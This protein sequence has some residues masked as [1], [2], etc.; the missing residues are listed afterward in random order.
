MS[1]KKYN[2]EIERILKKAKDLAKKAQHAS[3]TSLH[4]LW[5]LTTLRN[6]S[7]TKLLA[8]FD[9]NR[10]EVEEA[11]EHYIQSVNKPVQP[12]W[13]RKTKD[14]L[15][16][17]D[18]EVTE[19]HVEATSLHLLLALLMQDQS[20][21]GEVV[22][23]VTEGK[24]TDVIEAITEK[25]AAD[26]KEVPNLLRALS[27]ED[28]KQGQNPL[29]NLEQVGRNLTEM[30]KK[31]QLDPVFGRDKE[32]ERAL[33]ILGRRTKNNPVF[34]G[35]PGVGK[36]AIA[37][38]VAQRM[39]DGD[40]PQIFQDKE[41]WLLDISSVVAGTKYRGE[42]ENR[43]KN[44]IEEVRQAGNIILFIDELHTLIGAGGSE[45]SVDASNILKPALSRGEIQ[46]MGATTFDEY[47]KYIEKDRAFERRFAPIDIEEPS[48]EMTQKMLQGLSNYYA[49]YHNVVLSDEV[50]NVAVTLSNRFVTD[51]QLPDKAIDL[52][53]EASSKL[54]L[55]SDKGGA[56]KKALRQELK[57]METAKRQA[58]MVGNYKEATTIQEK[59]AEKERQ[60]KHKQEMKNAVRPEVTVD[61]LAEVIAEWTGIPTQ[62]IEKQE[63]ERLLHLEEEL[64]QRVIGQDEA[65]TSVARAIRRSRSGLSNPSRPI[66][67]FM[68]LGPTGVGKTELAK[69]LAESLFGDEEALIRVDMS[70][71]MS[72]EN[73]SRLI[74]SAP[75]YVGYDEGGQLTEKVRHKPYSVILFDEVEK[76][77]PDVFNMLLQILDDGHVT[78]AKGRKVDFK[79]TV[80]IMTS[81]LGATELR[82]DKQV[83]FGAQD[84]SKNQEAVKSKMME[85]LKQH[86]RPEFL[87]RIDET[88]VF[89]PLEESDME[90]IVRLMLQSI[91]KR[92]ELQGYKLKVTPAAVKHLAKEGHNAEYGARPM[93]R[94]L[95]KEVEDRLAEALLS[96]NL[97]DGEQVTIG[98]KHNQL[99][100]KAKNTS[101]P[102][103]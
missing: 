20:M 86:F 66:G 25:I 75:G 87:N 38:G 61:M 4:I 40:V 7:A 91:E 14:V 83:G 103:A 80:I 71:Y 96:G 62:Q 53:D 58:I 5:A 24:R 88:I 64:H 19:M 15:H 41:V 31:G 51:R 63:S 21:A 78:D 67:S 98:A 48:V 9:V 79:N 10:H 11:V 36:T 39:A 72:K 89:H 84:L 102:L 16:M 3:I 90:K 37:E 27:K 44:I 32:I 12:E 101:K 43:M 60:L 1:Q 28:V 59:Q 29:K 85:A 17:M 97:V 49:D 65:V 74:G 82:D 33:Q 34:R 46:M 55:D 95:Q 100:L 77:H 54:K 18:K 93:Q 42:F 76:A 50:L 52:I 57:E 70:E 81:N 56:D 8:S 22:D 47:Q 2:A 45:G 23:V 68:F 30:A 73:V 99:Y 35:E 94:L 6:N 69:T 13:S 92:M 26:I